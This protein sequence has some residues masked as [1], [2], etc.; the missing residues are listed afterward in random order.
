MSPVDRSTPPAQQPDQADGE[1]GRRLQVV[2]VV[3]G[4]AATVTENMLKYGI[5]LP[6][7]EA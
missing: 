6:K 1:A 2:A 5:K 7:M 4:H 3:L